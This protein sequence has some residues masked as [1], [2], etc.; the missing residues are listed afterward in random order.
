MPGVDH[1]FVLLALGA[2]AAMLAA[3]RVTRYI[4][5][6]TVAHPFTHSRIYLRD[7]RVQVEREGRRTG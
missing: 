3:S 2:L 6:E 5:W 7:G 1:T 4:F